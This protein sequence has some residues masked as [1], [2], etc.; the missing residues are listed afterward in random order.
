MSRHYS[1]YLGYCACSQALKALSSQQYTTRRIAG[2]SLR[3]CPQ[4]G[5]EMVGA[6][7][8]FTFVTS[9][10]RAR[11]CVKRLCA[12]V[13]VAAPMAA[14]HASASPGL[15]APEHHLNAPRALRTYFYRYGVATHASPSQPMWRRAPIRLALA[16]ARYLPAPTPSHAYSELYTA[17]LLGD[18]PERAVWGSP[19]YL[20][21]CAHSPAACLLC[22]RLHTAS[23]AYRTISQPVQ[24]SGPLASR[25]QR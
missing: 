1:T 11:A 25:P 14:P 22:R 12:V 19:A 16:S 4:R 8:F 20:L 24:R 7:R 2:C 6:S 13:V 10:A 17:S 9:T 21:I 3:G 23:T 18:R 15:T 5:Q